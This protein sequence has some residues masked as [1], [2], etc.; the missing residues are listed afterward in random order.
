MTGRIGD[1]TLEGSSGKAKS[2]G[3]DT[4]PPGGIT[5]G[6]TLDYSF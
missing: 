2:N 6:A 1:V 4:I 5:L 3:G